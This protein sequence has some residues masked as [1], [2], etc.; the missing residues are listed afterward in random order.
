MEL[1]L[2]LAQRRARDL[3]AK[4]RNARLSGL[5][6]NARRAGCTTGYCPYCEGNRTFSRNVP[7]SVDI[8]EQLFEDVPEPSPW[9]YYDTAAT[10]Y[11][12]WDYAKAR[13]DEDYQVLNGWQAFEADHDPYI[14]SC[15]AEDEGILWQNVNGLAWTHNPTVYDREYWDD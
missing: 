14:W 2:E 7:A 15:M 4:S 3:R 1:K 12:D 5:S 13:N 9:T 8:A 11:G 10:F 6:I